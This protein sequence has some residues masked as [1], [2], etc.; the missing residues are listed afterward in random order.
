MTGWKF[1][2]DSKWRA[3]TLKDAFGP[4]FVGF[5]I[6]A[7]IMGALCWWIKGPQVFFGTLIG[8]ADLV[9]RLL[10][11]VSVALSIAALIWVMLPRDKVSA[12]V[13]EKS[14]MTGLIIASLAGT[15][16]PGG[17][18]AA[19]ALLGVLAVSGAGRGALVAYITA[20]ATL[21]LQRILLWDVPFMGAEFAIF[22]F[23]V[24]LPLPV[25][26]GLIAHYLPLSLHI[27]QSETDEQK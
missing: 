11:R 1:L 13:G 12:L 25:I 17:P 2:K 8:D 23:L 18:T 16:T 22:R 3:A 21:G 6:F 14:G 10:P 20:W 24:G 4:N 27:K 9:L 19:Y 15:V 7:T 5:L 26:A